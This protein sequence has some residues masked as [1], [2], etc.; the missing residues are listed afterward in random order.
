MTLDQ[1]LAHCERLHPKTVELT[2][3]RVAGVKTRLGIA[4]SAP[5][6]TS[7]VAASKR[8]SSLALTAAMRSSVSSI[9]LGCSRSQCASHSARSVIAGDARDPEAPLDEIL[10]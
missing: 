10:R 4:F 7:A 9:V 5:T 3:D 8:R 1:W 6:I 2:L